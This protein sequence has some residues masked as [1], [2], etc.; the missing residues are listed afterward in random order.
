MGVRA[1]VGGPGPEL[2]PTPATPVLVPLGRRYG[3]SDNFQKC[4]RYNSDASGARAAAFSAAGDVT[5]PSRSAPDD[6]PAL[7]PRDRPLARRRWS[8]ASPSRAR[9]PLPEGVA[10]SPWPYR[11]SRP[12]RGKI[13]CL[14]DGPAQ[15]PP[16]PSPTRRRGRE[17]TGRGKARGR[18]IG[19]GDVRGEGR[20]GRRLPEDKVE[21]RRAR[22]P[23]SG[24]AASVSSFATV[25][26]DA[27][28]YTA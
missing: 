9:P 5:H 20:R 16:A 10:V 17:E 15:P 4:R 8:P 22:R 3:W 18:E 12:P 14:R 23:W 26:A 6:A 7:L 1:R 19:E 11:R 13:P 28:G 25:V 2:V 24:R 21:G 27:V